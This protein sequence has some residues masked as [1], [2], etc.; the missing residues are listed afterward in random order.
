MLAC[1][2][3]GIFFNINIKPLHLH[4]NKL[5]LLC[6]AIG[7][8][9]LPRARSARHCT[10]RHAR[11]RRHRLACVPLSACSRVYVKGLC[12]RVCCGVQGRV[13]A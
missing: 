11:T 9:L 6:K 10:R 7:L 5:V 3:H 12:L 1:E 2:Q 8:L 4:I 13:L